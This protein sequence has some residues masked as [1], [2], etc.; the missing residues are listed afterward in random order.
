[1]K[2]SAFRA[3]YALASAGDELVFT[4][5]SGDEVSVPAL[6]S[7]LSAEKEI[8][9]GG[10]VDKAT[11]LARYVAADLPLAASALSGKTL[12]YRDAQFRIVQSK[13][14]PRSDIVHLSITEK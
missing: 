5:A 6:V 14:H 3:L 1:M 2:E 13:R 8:L 10:T 9:V 12:R 7:T 4:L 11:F